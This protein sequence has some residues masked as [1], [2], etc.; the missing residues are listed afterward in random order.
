MVLGGGVVDGFW[1]DVLTRYELRCVILTLGEKGCRVVSAE[2]VFEV[3]G[4]KQAVVNTV[5]AG[6][7]FTAAFI[8]H[9]INGADLQLCAEQA[10]LAGG[11]VTTQDSGMPKLPP[12]FRV[13]NKR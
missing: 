8:S 7:A 5:G 9:L 13:F 4:E 11:F 12:S 2:C 10:N 3:Q 1:A 6:D